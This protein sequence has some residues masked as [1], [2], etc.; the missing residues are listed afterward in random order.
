MKIMTDSLEDTNPN[1]IVVSLL[2]LR[3]CRQSRHFDKTQELILKIRNLFKSKVWRVR[4]LAAETFYYLRI[5]PTKV[6]LNLLI[7]IIENKLQVLIENEVKNFSNFPTNELHAI[8]CMLNFIKK[9]ED[10]NSTAEFI[11]SFIAKI[12]SEKCPE[13]IK[14]E[15]NKVQSY[16]SIESKTCDETCEILFE[17][18]RL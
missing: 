16:S 13:I 12:D 17:N 14:L 10:N 5:V 6:R 3:Q 9:T 11:S 1:K 2:I 15:I 4:S 7:Q 8:V 18:I